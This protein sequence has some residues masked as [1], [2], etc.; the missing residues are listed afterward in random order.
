MR[1]SIIIPTYNSPELLK[2]T[3][4]CLVNQD[5]S[6]NNYEVII[7]DDGSDGNATKDV[8][9]TFENDLDI[10]YCYQ[11]DMGFR[12]G[13]A[14]NMGIRLAKYEICILM[15]TGI[16]IGKDCIKNIIKF[17]T[18]HQN[19]ACVGIVHGMNQKD[20][21]HHIAQ[22]LEQTASSSNPERCLNNKILIAYPDPRQTI[23]DKYKNDLNEFSAPW[24]L[25]WT[26]L[27][28]IEQK[29][30]HEVEMFDESFIGWG[31]EDIDLGYRLWEMGVN[32]RSDV[33]IRG[34]HLPH[35]QF[36]PIEL[37]NNSNLIKLYKKYKT[38]EVEL[39]LS[40][41]Y[42]D[43]NFTDFMPQ[44]KRNF[45]SLFNN[46]NIELPRLDI[47][48]KSIL[49][50]CYSSSISTMF[51]FDSIL[52]PDKMIYNDL[53]S[54]YPNGNFGYRLGLF[55]HEF[56]DSY[57]DVAI[58]TDIWKILTYKLA[59]MLFTEIA[60]IS[61]TIMIIDSLV[62]EHLEFSISD[63]FDNSFKITVNRIANNA[64]IYLITYIG[65]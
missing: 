34:L 45:Y 61:K 12:A 52:T 9:Q 20:E 21:N 10:R 28:S 57:Y 44:L 30:L 40:A 1:A 43:Y 17:H 16:I 47:R 24:S 8:T 51:N 62:E 2:R 18:E 25:F 26:C 48:G 11:P 38:L 59:A 50:G 4:L 3:M 15:D 5:L 13:S 37:T 46:K 32:F 36:S 23:Y 53:L 42:I 35:K 27:V 6:L 19:T 63:F 64:K 56:K 60:R 54:N 7:C 14:R 55:N 31:H 22:I 41:H 58:V 33:L 49:I 65:V 29:V 39:L